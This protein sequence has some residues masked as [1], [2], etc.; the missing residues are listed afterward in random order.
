[1]AL[2]RDFAQR[3]VHGV[4]I[5]PTELHGN[6]DADHSQIGRQRGPDVG[7]IRQHVHFA[8]NDAVRIHSFLAHRRNVEMRIFDDAKT[9]SERIDDCRDFDALA[10]LGDRIK[11]DCSD[12]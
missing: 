10:H 7:Q 5:A 2:L 8:A 4:R 9:V 6:A 1:M 11:R 12:R 3:L